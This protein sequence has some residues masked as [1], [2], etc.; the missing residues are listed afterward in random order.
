[1]EAHTRE[2]KDSYGLGVALEQITFFGYFASQK[3]LL[4][5]SP[6]A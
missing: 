1:L 4:Q 3:D 2:S 5:L 6:S